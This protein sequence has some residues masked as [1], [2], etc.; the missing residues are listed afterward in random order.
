MGRLAWVMG[1]TVA[2]MIGGVRYVRTSCA[3][4]CRYVGTVQST[5]CMCVQRT[6]PTVQ[7]LGISQPPDSHPP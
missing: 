1:D 2:R 7:Q 3:D 6:V 4:R 5:D